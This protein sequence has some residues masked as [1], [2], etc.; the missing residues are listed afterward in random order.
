LNGSGGITESAAAGDEAA[1]A[2]EGFTDVEGIEGLL[3]GDQYIALLLP[4][5]FHPSSL[6]LYIFYT[7]IMVISVA[8]ELPVTHWTEVC[9]CVKRNGNLMRN[10]KNNTVPR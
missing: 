10:K 5:R 7:V 6:S 3:L 8:S 9:V 2:V 1:R 4:H